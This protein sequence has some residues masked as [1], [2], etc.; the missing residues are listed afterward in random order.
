M[1]RFV[2]ALVAVALVVAACGSTASS[3]PASSAVQPAPSTAGASAASP[4]QSGAAAAGQTDTEWGR[5]WDTLPSNFPEIPGARPSEEAATGPAS[6]TL[7]LEGNVARLVATALVDSLAKNG[8]PTAG[9]RHAPGGRQL[10]ARRHR[11]RPGLQGPGDGQAD[12][13]RDLR[14]D[15]LRRGLPARLN[16]VR[17]CMHIVAAAQ[18]R[19]ALMRLSCSE[20]A[21]SPG[22]SSLGGGVYADCT[23]AGHRSTG[24][25]HRC[26]PRALRAQP[27]ARV[28]GPLTPARIDSIPNS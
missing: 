22:A 3:D 28:A 21:G 27:D 4:A 17:A 25:R 9:P 24:A 26:V 16:L 14:D 23:T 12:G 6:A 10:H 1:K 20:P 5:I 13:R 18:R 7:V 15:P 11:L 19:Q 2:L 8:F